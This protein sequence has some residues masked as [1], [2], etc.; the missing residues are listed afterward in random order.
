MI[1]GCSLDDDVATFNSL[2]GTAFGRLVGDP[3]VSIHETKA[4]VRGVSKG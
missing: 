1:D 2:V 3:N 4:F